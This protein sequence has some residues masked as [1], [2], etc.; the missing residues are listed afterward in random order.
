MHY[1][2]I[3]VKTEN[4][5]LM[6]NG[7]KPIIYAEVKVAIKERRR[8]D[9]IEVLKYIIDYVLTSQKMILPNQTIAYYSWMLK[10][11]KV[12]EDLYSLYEVNSAG[13]DYVEGVDHAI[14]VV[15]E[16]KHECS[17]IGVTPSF[18]AFNQMIAISKGVYEGLPTEAVRYPS[19]VHM[20]GW[21]LTTDLYNEKIESMMIVH[22]YHVAFKRPDVVKYLALPFGYRFLVGAGNDDVWYDPKTLVSES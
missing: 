15:S 8:D 2:E 21:W 5:S 17:K 11:V 22:Y 6:T 12:G 9:Y 18:P 7:L 13:E 10:F 3:E 14:K 19:P 1:R 16:Q 4:Q 20:S